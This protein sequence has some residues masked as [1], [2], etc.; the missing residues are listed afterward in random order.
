MWKLLILAAVA[1][2]SYY[3]YYDDESFSTGMTFTE[4]ME[5]P[6]TDEDYS[7]MGTW[8][9]DAYTLT[10]KPEDFYCWECEEAQESYYTKLYS[11]FKGKVPLESFVFPGGVLFGDDDVGTTIKKDY[12]YT[13]N[14]FSYQSDVAYTFDGFSFDRNKYISKYEQL[15]TEHSGIIPITAIE[16]AHAYNEYDTEIDTDDYEKYIRSDA[17][18]EYFDYIQTMAN[19]K[20]L[21]LGVYSVDSVNGVLMTEYEE[22]D[23]DVPLFITKTVGVSNFSNVT[24]T[25]ASESS[26]LSKVTLSASEKES[27]KPSKSANSSKED[28]SEKS[29]E[30][31]KGDKS[32]EAAHTDKSTES[33]AKSSAQSTESKASSESSKAAAALL[34]PLSSLVVLAMMI[35]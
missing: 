4:T 5:N 15:Y 35:I 2:A 33:S 16:G 27:S 26:L 9:K 13:S 3:D 19:I 1:T 34:T 20:E 11:E 25:T 14:P 22:A 10:A 18:S 31:T 7:S 32:S 29:S 24:A 28:K 6:K 17:K 23:Y 12:F 30:S 8:D 21:S